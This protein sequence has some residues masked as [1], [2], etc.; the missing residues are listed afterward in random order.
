[1]VMLARARAVGS[2]TWYRTRWLQRRCWV[3]GTLKAHHPPSINRTDS[4]AATT[5]HLR[6]STTPAHGAP[7][8]H[9]NG[10]RSRV[11][12]ERLKVPPEQQPGMYCTIST[13]FQQSPSPTPWRGVINA[14]FP[15]HFFTTVR[16]CIKQHHTSRFSED[17]RT[18]RSCSTRRP[19][20]TELR[21][22]HQ[23]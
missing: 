11:P 18:T 1:M 12:E 15:A 5:Y 23:Y 2:Q 13:D 4:W 6:H 19:S 8:R 3:L 21:P 10:R 16:V 17:L 22:Q 14:H 7:R 20:F 9:L